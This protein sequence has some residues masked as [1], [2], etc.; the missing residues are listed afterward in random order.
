MALVAVLLP[1]GCDR[2]ETRTAAVTTNSPA[3]S[4][5]APSSTSAASRDEALV[6]VV[7]AIPYAPALDVF[8]G[9]LV[10]FD[11]VNFKSVTSYRAL[12]GKRYSF[13]LRPAGMTNAKPMASNTEGL[14][15]GSYYT[16]FALP[17]ENRSAHM[18]VVT[19]QLDAARG[20]QAAV[21]R[22][23]CR[24]RRG[25]GGCAGNGHRGHALRSR[26]FSNRQRLPR[27][28]SGQRAD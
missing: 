1:L 9:D 13:A 24:R 11:A 18:R 16:V 3:G 20:R 7:H 25:R 17:G 19:D 15:D 22:R 4:S 28:R 10:L 21:A 2:T 14:Q 27:D 6:R 26:R 8:A 5:T 23:A 12:D